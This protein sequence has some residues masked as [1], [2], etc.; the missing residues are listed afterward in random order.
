MIAEAR[1]LLEEFHK[2][3][4][5]F[6][7]AASTITDEELSQPTGDPNNLTLRHWFDRLHW[8]FGT[9]LRQIIQTRKNLEP[10]YYA[11]RSLHLP[12]F[13]GFL[14]PLAAELAT[15]SLDVFTRKPAPEKMSVRENLEH[16]IK[17]ERDYIVPGLK[18]ALEHIRST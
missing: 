8:H 7:D 17:A 12:D 1:Q 13:A 6:L 5:E 14:G 11:H 2:V 3:H 18:R 10:K 4:L 15:I 9:H 16:L